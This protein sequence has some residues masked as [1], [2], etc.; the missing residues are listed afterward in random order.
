MVGEDGVQVP[1]DKGELMLDP[2]MDA[3]LGIYIKAFMF[4]LVG[5]VVVTIAHYFYSKE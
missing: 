5:L 2:Y 4:L 3:L 1:F